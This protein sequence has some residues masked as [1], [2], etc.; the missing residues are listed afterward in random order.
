MHLLASLSRSSKTCSRPLRHFFVQ[1]RQRNVISHRDLSS[2]IGK[3]GHIANLV[4]VWRPFLAPLYA[5]LYSID[6]T[7]AP[8]NNCW[9]RQI[10]LELD[11]FAA[12]FKAT[13]GFAERTFLVEQYLEPTN[14]ADL[15]SDASPWSSGG[16]LLCNRLP[17]EYFT[18]ALCNED[19]AR[20]GFELG[21]LAGQQVWERKPRCTCRGAPVESALA[22][23]TSM[24]HRPW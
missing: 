8:L 17:V 13:G 18:R 19:V 24:P 23:Q 21:D 9:T 6:R 20:F 16:V 12:F 15:V 1:V 2:L 7:R 3:L 11:W 4:V 5:A 22:T 14:A 10:A